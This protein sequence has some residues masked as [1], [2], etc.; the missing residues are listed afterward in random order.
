MS[1][2]R[3]LA[4]GLR[5]ASAAALYAVAA[6]MLFLSVPAMGREMS[7]TSDQDVRAGAHLCLLLSTLFLG[8]AAVV[9]RTWR[10]ARAW[11]LL[12]LVT[13]LLVWTQVPSL[14]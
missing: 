13:T 9:S 10:T 5:A 2:N 1:E 12:H 3:A 8:A 11:C 4:L 7:P 6:F 14:F